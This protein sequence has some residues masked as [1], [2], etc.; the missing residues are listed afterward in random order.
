MKKIVP[1]C[2][3]VIENRPLDQAG[4]YFRLRLEGFAPPR[5]VYPGQFIHLKV[6]SGL[7]PFFRRAFS[8]S[9]YDTESGTLEI[10]YKVLGRGTA[11]LREVGPRATLDLLG[12]LGNLFTVPPA[13]GAV[14]MAAGGVGLPPLAFLA[15]HLI[16]RGRDPKSV[17]F[18]YGGRTKT[19]LIDLPR[20]RRAGMNLILS[21]DDGSLGFH[22]MVTEAVLDHLPRIG[23]RFRVYGCGPEP[24]LAA[25]QT[26]AM[27]HNWP[28]E[29]S[30]EA[31]MPCGVGV[32]LGCIKP[33]RLH[34]GT[35]VRVCHDGPV[36][37]LGEVQL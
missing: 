21:T 9:D 23:R 35:Y 29:L 27:E 6:A 34:P 26:L 15:R 37:N 25:L 17:Y 14:V 30:L 31:P 1:Q 24:M 8:I 7:D 3:R 19:E 36:F 20:L 10:I 13:S 32:C 16:A 11:R 5:A 4:R 18:F 12:P 33:S 2:C 22:G 28:G